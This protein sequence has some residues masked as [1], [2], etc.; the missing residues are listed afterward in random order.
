[1]YQSQRPPPVTEERVKKHKT[2][3]EVDDKARGDEG[4]KQNK[5]YTSSQK[6]KGN[7]VV[8]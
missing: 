1:M 3:V 6:E 4:I 7:E 2:V 5:R 8:I